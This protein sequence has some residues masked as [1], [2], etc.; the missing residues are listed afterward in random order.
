M[1]TSS[2]TAGTLSL[3]VVVG[4]QAGLAASKTVDVVTHGLGHQVVDR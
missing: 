2:A 3:G 4:I 1:A